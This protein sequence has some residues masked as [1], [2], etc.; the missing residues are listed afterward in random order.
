MYDGK[1]IELEKLGYNAQSV[2]KIRLTGKSL[3]YDYSV[4]KY[5]EENNM[6]LITEDPENYGGCQ[7]NHL[8][9]I[10]LGQNPTIEEIVRELKSLNKEK[11]STKS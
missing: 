10:K 5:V 9:C 8:P 1:D 2:K 4:L 11:D 7:E 3:R 6:I